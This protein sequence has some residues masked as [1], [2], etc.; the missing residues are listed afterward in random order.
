MTGFDD[1]QKDAEKKFQRDEEMRF[2]VMARRAKMLGHWV[3][4]QLGLK[5]DA[6]EAYAKSMVAE[7]MSKPGD[8]DVVAKV[9]ADLKVKG[10]EM[11]EHRIRKELENFAVQA[12]EQLMK[13]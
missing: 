3:A 9:L 13:E 10:I 5:G 6:A 8:S 11:S 7:D 1:R 2:K 12:R 4:G